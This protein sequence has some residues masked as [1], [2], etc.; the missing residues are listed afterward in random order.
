MEGKYGL[1]KNGF[2]MGKHISIVD[3]FMY[4][5]MLM[6]YNGKFNDTQKQMSLVI[7]R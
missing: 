2:G 4:L 3:K 5:G 7:T 1:M 6:N